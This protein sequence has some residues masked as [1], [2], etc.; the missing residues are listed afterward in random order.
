MQK[1][2]TPAVRDGIFK[3]YFGN[4]EIANFKKSKVSRTNIKAYVE[5]PAKEERHYCETGQRSS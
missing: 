3:N 2:K 1:P 5:K 4:D